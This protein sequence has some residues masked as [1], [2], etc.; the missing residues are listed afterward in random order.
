M[1]QL[2]KLENWESSIFIFINFLITKVPFHWLLGRAQ[3]KIFSHYLN[4]FMLKKCMYKHFCRSTSVHVF[5]HAPARS[6]FSKNFPSILHGIHNEVD[7]I[8]RENNFKGFR[9]TKNQNTKLSKN[10]QYR[11]FWLLIGSSISIRTDRMIALS[12]S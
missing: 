8:R 2:S 7:G 4:F 12:C 1:F 9:N 3:E 5:F 10:D 6:R 11:N